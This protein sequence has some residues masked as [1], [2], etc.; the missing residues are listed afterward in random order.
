M[1]TADDDALGDFLIVYEKGGEVTQVEADESN[2]VDAAVSAWIDSGRTKDS[3]LYLSM[4]NGTATYRVLASCITSWWVSTPA[5]RRAHLE[6]VQR[7]KN[8]SRALKTEMGIP[9]SEDE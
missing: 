3:I 4:V 1:S 8:E 5:Y 6:Q 9:W 2:S 7:Q